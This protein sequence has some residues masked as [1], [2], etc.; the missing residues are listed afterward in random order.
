MVAG[1]GPYTSRRKWM[2]LP[3]VQCVARQNSARLRR[4]A[5]SHPKASRMTSRSVAP[6]TIHTNVSSGWKAC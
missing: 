2:L 5:V 1:R 3:F 4:S 6:A